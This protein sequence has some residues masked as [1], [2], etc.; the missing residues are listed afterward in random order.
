MI[1][2]GRDDDYSKHDGYSHDAKD[3]PEIFGTLKNLSQYYPDSKE[4]MELFIHR[5]VRGRETAFLSIR[6]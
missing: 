2:A 6:R 4:D 1:G 3:I 5:A